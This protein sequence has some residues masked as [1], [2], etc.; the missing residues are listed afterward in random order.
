MN[1]DVGRDLSRR[2]RT[3]RLC[4]LLGCTPS[5]LRDQPAVELDW[6]LRIDEVITE[7][8]ARQAEG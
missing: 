2:V 6:L 5:A 3:Y 1:I 8:E 7:H 4:K